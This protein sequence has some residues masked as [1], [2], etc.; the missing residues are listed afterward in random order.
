MSITPG[1]YMSDK[2]SNLYLLFEDN[3]KCTSWLRTKSSNRSAWTNRKDTQ[4]LY[5][6]TTSKLEQEFEVIQ[7]DPHG[8]PSYNSHV[9]DVLK[10][11]K[12]NEY[13]DTPPLVSALASLPPEESKEILQH[14]CFFCSHYHY[15]CQCK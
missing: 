12:N 4:K 13:S 3:S 9:I 11:I 5:F 14:F 6:P 15:H 7:Y 8:L 1:W 10:A 2:H